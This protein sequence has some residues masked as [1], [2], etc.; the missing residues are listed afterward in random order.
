MRINQQLQ[1]AI[2]EH[3]EREYPAEACGVLIKTESGREYV[4]CG[5]LAKTP[6]DQF[7]LNHEDLAAAE[8]RGE[9]LAI[10]HSH[11]D[12]APTPSMADRVSCEL[13]ELPWG[14]VGWPGGDIEWFKPTGY[15]APL[16]GREFSHGA[17]DCWGACRDW[18]AREADL[19]LPNFERQDLWW[20][21]PD[22]PSHYEDNFEAV[23]F[24]RVESPQRG[25]LL[26]FMV[27]SPGRPCYHPNHAA[28]YL[29]DEPG[30]TSED[31]PRLGG[32]GPFIYHHMAGRASVREVYGWSMAN[33]CRLT[34]RHKDYRP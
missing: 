34:L 12:A 30:L 6:R 14:I 8:D 33:R 13:H 3:A 21:D 32:A 9:L 25:D 27:P 20:E 2:R 19:Q 24:R 15:Q 10:I 22:G 16:L 29:G 26:I 4:P 28:I 18:Y 23:G 11:P 31:A 1:A 7:T 5:N 17:L